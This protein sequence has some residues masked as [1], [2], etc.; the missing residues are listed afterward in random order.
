MSA[1]N[2]LNAGIYSK[3]AGGTALV[4]ALGGTAIYHMQAP[5]NQPLPYVVW[6][7]AGG[8][9]TPDH[10]I[11]NRLEWVRA[12][13]ASAAQGGTI[14]ALF[15]ALLDGAVLTVTDWTNI[16]LMAEDDVELIETPPDG[17]HVYAIGRY[18]RIMLD[19]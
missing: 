5:D 11:V 15:D 13:A 2:A 17:G 7:W 4:A 19:R 18:Y 9:K 3:L 6:S 12:Y 16:G 8:G 14:C 1:S 10:D